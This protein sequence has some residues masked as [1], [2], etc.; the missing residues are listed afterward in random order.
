MIFCSW[1]VNRRSWRAAIGDRRS[2]AGMAPRR[3]RTRRDSLV[4]ERIQDVRG[5]DAELRDGVA[6]FEDENGWQIQLS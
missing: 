1:A 2:V 3:G 5:V 6:A 4:V